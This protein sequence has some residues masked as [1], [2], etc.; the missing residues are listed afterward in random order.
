MPGNVLFDL[1]ETNEL[2]L[3]LKFTKKLVSIY[4]NFSNFSS[5]D[6]SSLF[7]I[8]FFLKI[9]RSANFRKSKSPFFFVLNF[10]R[11]FCQICEWPNRTFSDFVCYRLDFLLN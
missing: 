11:A 10:R 4:T 5:N 6:K 1:E 3:F 9:W 8:V 2:F 7:V